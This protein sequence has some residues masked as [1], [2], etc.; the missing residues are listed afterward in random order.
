MGT[1]G[2]CRASSFG[3]SSD[4]ALHGTFTIQERHEDTGKK[5][6]IG[7][8]FNLVIP[9]NNSYVEKLSIRCFVELSCFQLETYNSANFG[10]T[11]A[12]SVKTL[13][14]IQNNFS[15][16]ILRNYFTLHRFITSVWIFV[17]IIST[18]FIFWFIFFV[19]LIT[20]FG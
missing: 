20:I 16:Y 18:L 13:P 3:Q 14:A 6:R 8:N 2:V 11:K 9:S 12:G 15:I 17:C 5:C 7:G 10:I 4:C 19:K 1:K